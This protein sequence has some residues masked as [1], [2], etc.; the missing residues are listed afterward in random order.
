MKYGVQNWEEIK[1]EPGQKLYGRSVD[2]VW[3]RLPDGKETDFALF[4]GGKSVAC[5]ALT[6]NNEVILARQF[7]PGPKEILTELPGGGLKEGEN[8]EEAMAR[9]LL[10]ETGY[11]GKVKLVTTL[12]HDAY[13]PRI[14][15][16]LVATECEKIAEPKLE[17]N[18]ES[19]EVVLMSLEDFRKHLRTGQLTDI[20]IGYLGLDYLGLL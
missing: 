4:S 18:G 1:R 10:E 19:V 17:D 5:L 9:E 7:R 12:F 2:K 14:K 11:Q 20:E 15:Y 16:A 6:K 13:S 3:F 8:P